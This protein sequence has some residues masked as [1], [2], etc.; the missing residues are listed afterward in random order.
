MFDSE[1]GKVIAFTYSA[2]LVPGDIHAEMSHLGTDARKFAEVLHCCW[3]ITVI[4]SLQDLACHLYVLHFSLKVRGLQLT[5]DI[6][7]S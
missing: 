7:L 5:E 2:H 3:N 1:L 4:I 6:L